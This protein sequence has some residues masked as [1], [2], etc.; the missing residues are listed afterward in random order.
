MSDTPSADGVQ[1]ADATCK[2]PLAR[3]HNATEIDVRYAWLARHSLA[4]ARER[5]PRGTITRLYTV[6]VGSGTSIQVCGHQ[7]KAIYRHLD[8]M[9]A[10]AADATSKARDR[11]AD[12]LVL[13]MSGEACFKS[14]FVATGQ[15]P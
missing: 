13:N 1:R 12:Q 2:P 11:W 8:G 7:R 14:G 10:D 15:Q 3:H 5:Y 9:A 6:T 4:D